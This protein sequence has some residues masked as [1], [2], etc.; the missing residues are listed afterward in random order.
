MDLP[1]SGWYPDPYG[2]PVCS[3]GG[4]GRAGPSTPIPGV[5]AGRGRRRRRASGDRRAGCCRWPAGDGTA[6]HRRAGRPCRRRPCSASVRV[7]SG[8][9]D[10]RQRCHATAFHRVARKTKPPNGPRTE[11][12]PALPVR[13]L[14]GDR[15]AGRVPGDGGPAV[16][17]LS[18]D[19]GAAGLP[20]AGLGRGPAGGG[21]GAGTQ[22]MSCGGDAVAG[23]R[24]TGRARRAGRPGGPGGPG[25][26]GRGNPYGYQAGA[27]A[28]AHAADRRRRRRDRVAIAAIAIIAIEPGQFAVR[29]GGRPVADRGAH[30]DRRRSGR[31]RAVRDRLGSASASASPDHDRERVAADR[32][33]V[34]AVLRV[35]SPIPW[36]ATA[37]CPSTLNNG[38]FPWTDGEYAPAGQ[39]NG[40]AGP[41]TWYGE[42]C[43]GRCP[44]QY[45]YTGTRTCRTPRPTSPRPSRTPTTTPSTT[46]SPRD[47]PAGPGQRPRRPG[48]SPMTSPTPTRRPGGHL[49]RRGGRGRRRR[50]RDG[51]RPR[52]LHVDPIHPRRAN[53]AHPGLLPPTRRVGRGPPPTGAPPTDTSPRRPRRRERRAAGT[54]GAT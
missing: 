45:G 23:A 17:R 4:T 54:A 8:T 7:D 15:P 43:S 50:H 9:G 33:A 34:G 41:T 24:R 22:V 37:S 44:Q 12:Q 13:P 36:Q 14:A 3:A 26:P 19:H 21:D 48:R 49:D 1:P 35:S 20:A 25:G 27:A 39:V 42:A 5:A 38:A 40:D 32:R 16:Q 30:A 10:R 2:A 52:L 47:R 53:I 18:A 29:S 28:A 46:P 31:R 51:T 6:R 11:P